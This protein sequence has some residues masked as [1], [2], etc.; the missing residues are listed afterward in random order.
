META[1]SQGP[2][3][4]H[5]TFIIITYM[6]MPTGTLVL[7]PITMTEFT[8]TRLLPATLPGRIMLALG[9]TTIPS[10]ATLA[11]I[12]LDTSSWSREYRQTVVLHRVRTQ[13]PRSTFLAI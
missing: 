2:M 4:V 1:V 13:P 9:S 12:S 11:Q 6:T 5:S 7:T 3:P 10:M 8:V